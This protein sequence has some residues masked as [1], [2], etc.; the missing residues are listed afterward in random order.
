[1]EFASQ[2]W[3]TVKALLIALKKAK[4]I[5]AQFVGH[6]LRLEAS[7]IYRECPYGFLSASSYPAQ[8]VFPLPNQAQW[9]HLR[10]QK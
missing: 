7:M 3:L 9:L 2:G 8:T 4:T 6:I 1:L 10:L 5:Q